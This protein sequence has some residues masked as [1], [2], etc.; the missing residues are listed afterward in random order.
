MNNTGII[1]VECKILIEPDDVGDKAGEE[2]TII[3]PDETKHREQAATSTGTLLAI[4]GTAFHDWLDERKP[5]VGDRIV[6]TKYAGEVR[7]F[8]GKEY[9]IANDVDICAILEE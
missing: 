8:N 9:R 3:M 4:G 7:K 5:Q 1:P 6:F 2:K